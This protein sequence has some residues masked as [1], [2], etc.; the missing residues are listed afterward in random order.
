MATVNALKKGL[1]SFDNPKLLGVVLNEA[2]ELDQG[3]YG[4]SHYG[5][6]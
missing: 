1:E 5:Y 2:S 4:Y 3:N 6:K